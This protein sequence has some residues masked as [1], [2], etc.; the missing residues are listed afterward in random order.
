MVT[1]HDKRQVLCKEMTSD[2]AK[3]NV[4]KWNMIGGVQLKHVKHCLMFIECNDQACYDWTLDV[5]FMV[6][7][8]HPDKSQAIDED[9]TK[10][11][12]HCTNQMGP[13]SLVNVILCAHPPNSMTSV[14]RKAMI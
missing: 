4:A 11:T 7:V 6:C 13:I 2:E 5:V 9:L 12:N 3:S 14:A 1:I 8:S 10:A